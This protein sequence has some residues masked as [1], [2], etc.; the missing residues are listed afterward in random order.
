MLEI[1]QQRL[2]VKIGLLAT[3]AV[4]DRLHAVQALL[5]SL[6]KTDLAE[7]SDDSFIIASASGACSRACRK[8]AL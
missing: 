7:Q 8:S 3:V 2:A 5:R 4:G 1:I 6:L